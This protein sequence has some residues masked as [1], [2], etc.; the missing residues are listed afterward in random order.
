MARGAVIAADEDMM[1]EIG[2]W[3]GLIGHVALA[4]LLAAAI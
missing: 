3:V 4:L 1:R 2:R